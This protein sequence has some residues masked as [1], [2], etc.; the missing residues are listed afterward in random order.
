MEGVSLHGIKN[1]PGRQ[2]PLFLFSAS[3]KL[4]P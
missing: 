1:V 2:V 4:A 3:S